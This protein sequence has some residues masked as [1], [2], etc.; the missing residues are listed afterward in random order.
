MKTSTKKMTV[1][2]ILVAVTAVLQTLAAVFPIKVFGLSISLVMI[3]IVVASVF[4]GYVGG[5][6]VG[7]AFGLTVFVHCVTGLDGLGLMLFQ[8]NPFYTLLATVARGLIVGAV[9]AAVVRLASGI[10][11]RTL[12]YAVVAAV[13]P[14]V[15]TGVFLLLFSTLF[16]STLLELASGYGQ[17]AASFVV[18]TLVGVNFLFELLTTAVLAPPVCK[19]L[20]KVA[21]K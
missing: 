12:R 10:A 7:G 16:N 15:N 13:A 20:E 19:A 18:F 11:N 5:L 1:C 9:T 3:P 14:I 6:A 8:I 2:A 21:V 4:Y 17:D